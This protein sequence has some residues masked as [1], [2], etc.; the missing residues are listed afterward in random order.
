MTATM[1]VVL[2]LL[3]LGVGG[4]L[5]WLL[6][7]RGAGAAE[8]EHAA[9]R[10]KLAAALTDLGNTTIRA[11]ELTRRVGEVE[12]E[13]G[14]A[15]SALS[16]LTARHETATA[17]H[18]REVAALKE[19]AAGSRE[20]H[21]AM[22]G[23][24]DERLRAL[25]E[26]L[27]TAEGERSRLASELKGLTS[28]AEAN[29][30]SFERELTALKEARE[31]LKATFSQVG[32][33]LLKTTQAEF[34]KRADDRFKQSE[35]ASGE[36]LKGLMKPV[37][38]RLATYE[39]AV[40][41]VEA[42]RQAAYGDLKGVIGEVR[43]GQERVQ[44]EA[45]RLVNSLRNAPKARGR[46]GEQQLRN[47]LESCG[48]TEH[49]D[50]HTEVS[51][52][53]DDGRLRPDATVQVPGGQTLIID[54]KVSLNAYQDAYNADDEDGRRVSMAAHATAMKA[55]VTT[56]GAKA[57]QNQFDAAP[58]YV[59]M[60]V[61]GEHFLSAALEHDPGLWD[62]AFE[63]NVL[64]A[65][66]TN[67][68]AIARTVAGVWRQEK[69]AAEATQIAALGKELFERIGVAADHLKTVG[70]HLG[71]AVG[72]Y[73]KLA[74]SFD[75]RLMTTGRR[76]EQLNVDTAGRKLPD[77]EPIELLPTYSDAAE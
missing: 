53:T 52:D 12:R 75:T 73:N 47:V 7:R 17:A 65:T 55:H 45:A 56:L 50:F 69:V 66:P 6:A 71:K 22:L 43:V 44:A 49:V 28:E 3:A 2:I 9:L 40:R 51:V 10:E 48:L 29:R 18:E 35:T 46:W 20:D 76:F 72:S 5:G 32:G 27:E 36:A 14:Q 21:A 42:D 59:V 58:D 30:R 64:L 60:F 11:D 16:G 54:A 31:A 38:D 24:R 8:V 15:E 1:A 13:R 19:A 77:L 67:L 25:S 33:E 74:T 4:A 70:G 26:R 62:Y 37:H 57:Y 61:P 68:V 34:L 23:E 41:K 63:K 39:E